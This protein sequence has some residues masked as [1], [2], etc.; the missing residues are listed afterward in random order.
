MKNAL[1]CKCKSIETFA[2]LT[3]IQ[4]KNGFNFRFYRAFIIGVVDDNAIFIEYMNVEHSLSNYI[5]RCGKINDTLN[6]VKEDLYCTHDNLIFTVDQCA[7]LYEL[8]KL[9]GGVILNYLIKSIG[10]NFK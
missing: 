9:G 4:L 2:D 3:S 6:L 10:F 5:L 1:Q 8:G 7:D